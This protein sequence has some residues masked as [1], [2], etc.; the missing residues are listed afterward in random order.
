M[1]QILLIG[2]VLFTS[3]KTTRPPLS[4]FFGESLNKLTY[5]GE[6]KPKEEVI[7]LGQKL[8][9]DTRLSK[10]GTVS[11]SR[12]HLPQLHFSDG[13]QKS[14]GTKDR[15]AP[16][17]AQTLINT[18]GQISQHWDGNRQDVE[19]Q[20]A[21][22]FFIKVP[23]DLDNEEH[24]KEKLISNN[25]AQDFF[26]AFNVKLESE[27]AKSLVNL[28]AKAIG[29]FER[30][31]V[32]P[33]RFDDYLDGNVKRL[34]VQEERGLK[35][36][37]DYGCIGCHSG[38]LVGGEMY[39]KFGV[40]EDPYKY[41][42]SEKRDLGRYN[43]TKNEDD[44]EFFKVP[45]L[46]NVTKTAPYFHDGSVANLDQAVYIMGKVQLGID[47]AKQDRDDIIAFLSTL[48]TKEEIMKQLSE[49]PSLP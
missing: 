6:N 45:P 36:F 43:F 48:E 46:R 41:T 37:I 34:T 33:S 13:L 10:D 12:C 30:T 20:A 5:F 29:A 39:Q 22:S 19:E 44:K 11:C 4:E 24:L 7:S 16:R 49:I 14:R 31:L 35:K 2:L 18:A 38:Q 1:K 9:Y 25:Y 3:C 21:K 42:K 32:G 47:I 8:F 40:V 26:K 27:D 17:N 28:S 15:S 23:F